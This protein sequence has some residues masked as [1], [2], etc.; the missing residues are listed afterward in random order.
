MK[1]IIFIPVVLIIFILSVGFMYFKIQTLEKR[2]ANIEHDHQL[3]V[4][5]AR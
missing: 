3:Q 5:P 4:I 1:K 2:I